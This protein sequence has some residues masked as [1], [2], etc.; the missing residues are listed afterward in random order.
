MGYW[1]WRFAS[2][3][4]GLRAIAAAP[5]TLFQF[6]ASGPAVDLQAEPFLER[7]PLWTEPERY[8][9][10]QLAGREARQAGIDLLLY[11]SVRDPEGG[12]C[13]A[14]LRPGS[15]RPRRPLAQETW[16]LT[17]KTEGAIWQRERQRFVFDFV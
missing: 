17:I 11:R 8:S 14:V 15:F 4:E 13:V 9:N 3:S 5:Q 12:T 7:E 1:R 16:H 10:T 6:G 2:A